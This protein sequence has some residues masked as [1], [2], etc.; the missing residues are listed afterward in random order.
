MT[1]RRAQELKGTI[2]GLAGILGVSA[3]L[4]LALSWP[5][6]FVAA[7]AMLLFVAAP[8]YWPELSGG[9]LR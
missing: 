2:V 6:A 1:V 3:H 4:D 9:A 5:L 8:W 7:L